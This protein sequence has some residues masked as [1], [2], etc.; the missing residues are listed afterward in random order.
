MDDQAKFQL[1]LIRLDQILV[2]AN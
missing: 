2:E 1:Q